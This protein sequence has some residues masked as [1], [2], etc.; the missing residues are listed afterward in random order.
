MP[1][2]TVSIDANNNVSVNP[3]PAHAGNGR[4]VPF[5]WTIATNGWTFTANGIDIPA[6]GNQFSGGHPSAQGKQFHWVDKN[7]VAGTYKYNVNVTNN[8]VNASL[9]PTIQN[10]GQII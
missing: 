1:N 10:Q 6:G 2:I 7:D 5:N 4:N 8:S 9:D 3:D